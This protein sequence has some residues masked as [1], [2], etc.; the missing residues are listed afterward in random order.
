MISNDQ[1]K[2]FFLT[3]FQVYRVGDTNRIQGKALRRIKKGENLYMSYIDEDSNL[4][5]R[6]DQLWN[7]Y[8]FHCKCVK[9]KAESAAIFLTLIQGVKN[10]KEKVKKARAKQDIKDAAVAAMLAPTGEEGEE[11]PVEYKA[12]SA[13]M[14]CGEDTNSPAFLASLDAM[15]PHEILPL[16]AYFEQ[17]AKNHGK[18]FESVCAEIV[19]AA[20]IGTVWTWN[21]IKNNSHTMLTSRSERL[22]SDA[23]DVRLTEQRVHT[24]EFRKETQATDSA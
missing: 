5:Y 2:L 21:Y 10:E 8:G 13:L 11:A 14:D 6:Q 15:V 4:G 17:Y 19:D 22:M 18:T 24:G 9:C 1:K 3:R 12:L 20:P 7:D 23:S 16:K